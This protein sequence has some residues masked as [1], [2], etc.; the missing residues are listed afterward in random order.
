MASDASLIIKRLAKLKSDRSQYETIWL[1]CYS[2]TS[3]IRGHGFNGSIQD[4]QSIPQTRAKIMDGVTG[5]S[6]R[7]LSSSIS[8]GIHPSNAQW[9]E[10]EVAN[11]SEEAIQWLDNAAEAI[12]SNIHGSNFDAESFEALADVVIAGWFVLYIDEDREKGGLVFQQWPIASCYVTSTRA[13]GRIDTICREYQLTA[14]QC[15]R[16]F[17]E[18]NVSDKTRKLV[19]D[20]KGD[21]MVKLAVEIKPRSL[22]IDQPRRATE[23]PFESVTVEVESRKTVRESGYH[24]F[25][26]VVPRW[27]RIPESMYGVGPVLDALP[28]SM[29]LNAMKRIHMGSAELSISGMWIAED[30]GVLNPRTIKVGPRKIIVANSVDSMKPLNPPGNW[31]LA[32]EEI[33]LA[34]ASIRKIL[35][36]DQLQPQDGP[37]MTATEVHVRQQLIRQLL[38]PVFGRFQAEYL[39]PLIDRTFGLLFRAGL[40]GS[41][42]KSLIGKEY[43]VKY[44]SPMARAQQLE[45][46]TAIERFMQDVGGIA[47]FRPE[48]LDNIN[49]DEMVRILQKGLG[50]PTE[51]L[52]TIAEV[53]Q[54]RAD[55]AEQQAQQQQQAM[56]QEMASRAAPQLAQGMMN[57]NQG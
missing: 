9:A 53:E 26:C 51:I 29:M 3:P 24:E 54:V 12:Y 32:Q 41:P 4:G 5:D 28:D 52:L 38:G 27:I 56:M 8:S 21:E 44:I 17:G 22:K 23:L 2:V 11:A 16:Q 50:A 40:L 39:Q 57:A 48:A 10:L 25:P 55:R 31:Q 33:K 46:V 13:D 35:M 20:D 36:S 49:M 19:A 42:P 14:N 47:Q 6:V 37:A 7:L 43:K 1:D 34:Q 30:D 18:T 15:V 45:D